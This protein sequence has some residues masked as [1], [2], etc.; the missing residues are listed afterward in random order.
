MAN[1]WRKLHI[2]QLGLDLPLKV[3]RAFLLHT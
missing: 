2:V 3:N 1:I